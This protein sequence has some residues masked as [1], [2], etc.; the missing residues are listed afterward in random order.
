M[1]RQ[2]SQRPQ[3]FGYQTWEEMG[4]AMEDA[5]RKGRANQ[6]IKAAGYAHLV[7][8]CSNPRCGMPLAKPIE[9]CPCKQDIA[10]CSVM[11]QRQDRKRHRK[12][13]TVTG[14]RKPKTDPK[15]PHDANASSAAPTSAAA[16]AATTTRPTATLI[17]ATQT[18]LE[19]AMATLSIQNV[20]PGSRVHSFRQTMEQF[21]APYLADRA[22]A[23]ARRTILFDL[24]GVWVHRIYHKDTNTFTITYREDGRDAFLDKLDQHGYAYGVFSTVTKKNID[25]LVRGCFGDRPLACVLDQTMCDNDDKDWPTRKNLCK[26]WSAHA[27]WNFTSRNMILVDDSVQK[28]RS[29]PHHVVLVDSFDG[30]GHT[31]AWF[32][33]LFARIQERF[34][35]LDRMSDDAV[36]QGHDVCACS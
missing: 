29:H 34:A 10:Y 20:G 36:V 13:C 18:D 19:Q 17:H 30:T 27:H 31:A 12:K 28:T 22:R 14:V 21:D 6:A 23:L 24:N 15:T 16:A 11:C 33:G 26:L 2:S 9:Y 32:D 3:T 5:K 25:R 8:N 35:A 1:V 4:D 7:D